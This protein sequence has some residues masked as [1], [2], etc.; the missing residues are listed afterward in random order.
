MD[1]DKNDERGESNYAALSKQLYSPH[2]VWLWRTGAFEL[3]YETE[4]DNEEFK[5]I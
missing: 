5:V 1:T 2:L 3:F 4:E